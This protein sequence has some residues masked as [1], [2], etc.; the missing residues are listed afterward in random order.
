MIYKRV[1][2]LFTILILSTLNFQSVQ[3]EKTSGLA[4][5]PSVKDDCEVHVI[6]NVPYVAQEELIYCEYAAVEMVLEYYGINTSQTE[7]LYFVGGGY[8]MAYKPTIASIL[9]PP[10][11]HPPFKFRFCTDEICGGTED[12][13]FLAD[14]L[15]L[16]FENIYPELVISHKRC[17]KEYWAQLKDYVKNDI[18]VIT[19]LDPLVWPPYMELENITFWIP[20]IFGGHH[21]VVVIGFNE[22]NQTVC[23]NDPVSGGK[24]YGK[25]EKGTYRWVNLSD[26][27]SAVS[28]I[29]WEMKETRYEMLIFKKVTEEPPFPKEMLYDLAHKRNIDKM[30]G[31]KSAYDSDFMNENYYKFGIN[32]LETLKG[33]LKSKFL[34]RIPA[35]KL[36]AKFYPLT[37]PFHEVLREMKRYFDWESTNKKLIS[38]YLLNNDNMSPY[39]EKDGKLLRLEATYWKNLSESAEKLELA[40]VNN[41]ILKAIVLSK[42]IL[43]KMARTLDDVI[44]LEKII[45][46]S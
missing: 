11:I 10:A 24:L 7:I 40:V 46:Y 23:V 31:L 28:R 1:V 2:I 25:P 42:P 34:V 44:V 21:I 33:D 37:Y 41:S 16:S 17:W 26:F 8:S 6:K 18:P 38:E 39:N 14:M 43:N 35:F 4:Y 45:A 27:R 30:R 20:K 32:A 19:G 15:G 12:Y 5:A 22:T 9:T 36:I 3:S 29:L 13:K